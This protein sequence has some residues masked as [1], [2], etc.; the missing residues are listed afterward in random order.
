MEKFLPSKYLQFMELKS[1]GFSPL[2]SILSLTVLLSESSQRPWH[3]GWKVRKADKWVNGTAMLQ[4]SDQGWFSLAEAHEKLG[5]RHQR[6]CEWPTARTA[7]LPAL[8]GHV[9]RQ[10][11][12]RQE[13]GDPLGSLL[14]WKQMPACGHHGLLGFLHK[15]NWPPLSMKSCLAGPMGKSGNRQ[16]HGRPWVPI[17][18]K[19]SGAGRTAPGHLQCWLGR[20]QDRQDFHGLLWIQHRWVRVQRLTGRTPNGAIKFMEGPFRKQGENTEES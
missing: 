18:G 2:I 20:E 9:V 4:Q 19:E 7:C 14:S 13:M 17:P 5:S 6:P 8:A 15:T 10:W 1:E 12:D 3:L 11:W 16:C